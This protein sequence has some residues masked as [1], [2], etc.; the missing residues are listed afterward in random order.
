MRCPPLPALALLPALLLG[1]CREP[2]QTVSTPRQVDTPAWQ[3]P[4]AQDQAYS[5]GGW[6]AGDRAG[7]DEQMRQRA[8]AQ[9]DYNRMK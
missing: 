5:A 8:Q 7:W 4:D 9:N 2:V 1:A 3:G 6:T